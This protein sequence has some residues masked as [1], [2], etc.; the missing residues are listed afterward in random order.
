[1]TWKKRGRIFNLEGQVKWASHSFMTPTPWQL[2][3]DTI[4]IFG[5]MRDDKG[6]SRIGYIDVDTYN[7]KIVK[8]ISKTP[9]LDIGISGA[10]DDNGLI[11]GDVIAA[12]DNQIYMYYV[13]FQLVEKVKF[14]AF[15]GLAISNDKGYSFSRYSDA[16]ILDRSH[17][18]L[19]IR[20]IHTVIKENSKWRF[21]CGEGRRW[22][23][24]NG[25]AYP[26]YE[27]WYTESDDGINFNKT[28][29]LVLTYRDGE[30]RIG[31]PRVYKASDGYDMYFTCDTLNKQ[32]FSGYAHSIDGLT[33]ERDDS[34]FLL[35]RSESGWD[36][37]MLCY[38]SLHVTPH[39]NKYIFYSGNGMGYSGIGYAEWEN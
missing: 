5:G 21:W 23:Y 8:K 18:G 12:N 11:L 28:E 16:P 19:Y 30:Y 36:C 31:R 14:L 39:G 9:I 2:N 22:H 37:E 25:I 6:I 29:Q 38:P 1:M 7:P 15:T 3:D 17:N 13:G 4:R 35:Q 20:A 34:K 24:I 27:I 33:W 10:F 32:Y 26:S